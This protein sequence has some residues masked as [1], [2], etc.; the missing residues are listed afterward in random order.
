MSH[1]G[2]GGTLYYFHLGLFNR[3]SYS[4]S[5]VLTPDSIVY[6]GGNFDF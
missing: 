6:H 4:R 3:C 5:K 1:F 2:L